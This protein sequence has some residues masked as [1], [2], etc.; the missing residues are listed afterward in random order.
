MIYDYDPDQLDELCT[1]THPRRQHMAGAGP[2]C[3]LATKGPR[4]LNLTC[5]DCHVFIPAKGMQ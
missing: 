1:C 4:P 5:E 2:C 3:H